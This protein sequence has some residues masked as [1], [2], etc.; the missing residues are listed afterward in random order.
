MAKTVATLIGVLF[1]LVAIV[2]LAAR[3]MT[4]AAYDR[5]LVGGR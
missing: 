5:D 2:F 4:K 1:I 3:F